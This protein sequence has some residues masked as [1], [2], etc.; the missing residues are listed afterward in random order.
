MDELNYSIIV[1]LM[2]AGFVSA[3]IDS[4]VGGGGLISLPAIMMTGISPVVALGTNKMACVMGALTSFISFVRSGKV[5]FGIIKYL[6]PLSFFGSICGV[7]TVQ[8]I[9]PDFLKPMVVVMLICVTIYS[10]LKKDWGNQS[11]YAGLNTKKLILAGVVA[12]GMGFY[13]GFFGPGTGSFMLFCFLC[14]GF[15]FIGSAANSRALN[16]ASNIAAAAFFS[17]LGLVNYYY[18]LPMG[19]GMIIGAVFGTRMALTKGAGYV[20][21]LFICMTTILIGKQLWD[22]FK[23]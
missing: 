3:F 22:M 13:D 7:Y 4:V 12:F 5:D 21:P 20:R 18:A 10:L 17:Y 16:F 19:I 14:I 1:M 23:N 6:F 8:L 15:D 9:P 2:V 11:T